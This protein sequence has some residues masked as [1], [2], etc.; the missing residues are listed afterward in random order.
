M[1]IQR[2]SNIELCRIVSILLVMLVHTTFA[3]FGWETQSLGI[4]TLA[5]FT[6]I[7]VNVFVLITGYFS[8]KLKWTTLIN[9]AFICFFWM[10]VKVLGRYFLGESFRMSN[11]FFIT[12]SNWF[13]PCYIGLLF[14]SPLLNLFCDKANKKTLLGGAF[15]LLLIEVWFDWLPPTPGLSIGT[16]GGCSVLSFAIL[17]LL[18]R[19]IK[20]YG[21]PV[22][23]KKASPIIYVLCSLSLVALNVISFKIGHPLPKI[24]YTYNNPIVILSSVAFLMMFEQM[25]FSSKI[26]NHIAKSTLAVLLGHTALFFLYTKQFNYIY[27]NYSGLQVVAY[28]TLAIIVVFCA[29]VAIDQIRLLLYKAVEKKMPRKL[30]NPIFQ[31]IRNE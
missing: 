15:S 28:W 30:I 5:A 8:V 9:I 18:A 29:S 1:A 20:L 16:Q 14:L 3:T 17:Y 7:G 23:F 26:V 12:K 19:Y 13:I 2:Q 4:Q 10:L 11:L 22:W 31:N 27:D 24:V 21:I 25:I 6:I